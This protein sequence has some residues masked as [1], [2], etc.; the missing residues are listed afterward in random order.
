MRVSIL[1][2]TLVVLATGCSEGRFRQS[3]SSA[4]SPT[5]Q[6]NEGFVADMS[7]FRKAG[8]Q[9]WDVVVF[10][11]PPKETLTQPQ[12]I[13][14]MRV[15]GLPGESLEIRDDGVY[16]DGKREAQPDRLAGIRYVAISLP[17]VTYPYK[18]AAD[19]Y[20]LVGDNTTN[21]F[22]SRFWG[23]LSRQ[24]ILGKVKNK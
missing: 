22:D 1:I 24:S 5:I 23:G 10:H 13:W 12:E 21:S 3:G 7:A 18:I 15:I 20:F 2:L 9:R 17:T 11:P 6:P 19:A 4:M 14:A 16:I 8:P